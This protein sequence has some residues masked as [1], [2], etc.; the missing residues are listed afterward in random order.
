MFLVLV[1]TCIDNPFSYFGKIQN[2]RHVVFQFPYPHTLSHHHASL[3]LPSCSTNIPHSQFLMTIKNA[4]EATLVACGGPAVAKKHKHKEGEC[5]G[6]REPVGVNVATD[7]SLG[8]L[9]LPPSSTIQT[10]QV[11]WITG[12]EQKH[13]ALEVSNQ[14]SLLFT[15]SKLPCTDW[16]CWF[17]GSLHL[18]TSHKKLAVL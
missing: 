16:R 4:A 3:L 1:F 6:S 2:T 14:G 11:V 13:T 5:L 15:N 17:W 10:L 8:Q 9:Q 12:T 18:Y 7:D